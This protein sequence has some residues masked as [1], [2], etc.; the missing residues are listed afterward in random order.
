MKLRLYFYFLIFLVCN[1]LSC[2]EL[3]PW[4]SEVYEFEPKL[5]SEYAHYSKVNCASGDVFYS[6]H[7]YYFDLSFA[8]TANERWSLEI[9]GQTAKT[10][11]RAF[12]I[13]CARLTGRYLWLDD[14]G[15]DS[16]V[17]LATGLT[18]S[19]PLK[20]SLHDISVFHHWYLDTELHV[21]IGKELSCGGP[22]WLDRAWVL[23]GLGSGT[24]GS[25]WLHGMLTLEKNLCDV[26]FLRLGGDYLRGFGTE[27]IVSPFA[28]QGY[29]SVAHGSFDLSYGYSYKIAWLGTMSLDVAMRLYAKNCPSNVRALILSLLIPFSL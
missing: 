11:A 28:F 9:E 5:I 3:A 21:A 20:Q 18:F 15:G 25:S 2:T 14:V 16:F 19:T 23:L 8:L 24:K 1:S 7:D 12:G 26:H 4:F 13:D 22:F 29:A 27:N 6:D 10:R 17:S